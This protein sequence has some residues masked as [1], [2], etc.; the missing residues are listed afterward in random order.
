MEAI[1]RRLLLR[2]SAH[3]RSEIRVRGELVLPDKVARYRKRKHLKLSVE[4]ARA[5]SPTPPGVEIYTPLA[6]PVATPRTMRLSEEMVK[7]IQDYISGAFEAEIWISVDPL[8]TIKRQQQNRSGQEFFAELY[9][10]CRYFNTGQ[11][12]N[13]EITLSS[14]KGRLEDLIRDHRD[15][16]VTD[17]CSCIQHFA[18]SG[19]LHKLTPILENASAIANRIFHPKHHA[20]LFWNLIY[21][22]LVEM[23]SD[24]ILPAIRVAWKSAVDSFENALGPLHTSAVERRSRYISEVAVHFDREKSL[25]DLHDLLHSCDTDSQGPAD[26]RSLR[27]LVS[28]V[29][30]LN[31][32]SEAQCQKIFETGTEILKRTQTRGFP[33]YCISEF[34]MTAHYFIG[35]GQMRLGN[36]DAGEFHFRKAINIGAATFGARSTVVQGDCNECEN[37]LRHWGQNEAADLVDRERLAAMDSEPREEVDAK[38]SSEFLLYF[39][40]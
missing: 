30:L 14:A 22:Y 2:N 20:A 9:L 11:T 35:V 29:N 40:I 27:V 31:D 8:R 18:A 33:R 1:V 7:C 39:R 37:W 4:V 3:K 34:Q 10:A 25:S 23:E 36:I 5:R 16:T 12:R 26:I 6:S 28:F 21:S 38:A 15:R 17:I 32:A 19:E 13:G 24:E